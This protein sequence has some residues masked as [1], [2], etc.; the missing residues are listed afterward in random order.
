MTLTELLVELQYHT[1]GEL[2]ALCEEHL[3]KLKTE[4]ENLRAYARHERSLG[5][6]APAMRCQELVQELQE[7]YAALASAHETIAVMR[8]VEP[9]E[10]VAH[11]FAHPLALELE[12][13]LADRNAN[14]ERAMKVIGEYRSAMNAIH[15][16]HS[17][18]FM[19]EPLIQEP[20]Q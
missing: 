20:K 1:G 6:E 15:E 9:M 7:T 8:Q 13:V 12:C 16:Q 3:L 2:T 11:R 17:P 5:S 14:W 19:G 4:N 10:E 18:T